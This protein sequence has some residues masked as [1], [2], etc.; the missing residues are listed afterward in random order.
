[1]KKSA[2]SVNGGNIGTVD[3]SYLRPLVKMAGGKSWIVKSYRDILPASKDVRTYFEPFVGGGAVA[4][5]YIGKIPCIIG[6]KNEKLVAMYQGV[7]SEVGTI[8]KLLR[9]LTYDKDVYMR[10]RSDFN[11]RWSVASQSERAAWFLYLNKTC[12][13]GLFRTNKRGEFN[14]P[15]GAY[16]TPCI[17]DEENL[18]AWNKAFNDSGVELCAADFE[19]CLSLAGEGDFALIDPPYVPANTTTSTFTEYQA[20]GFGPEDQHRL[21]AL[22]VDLDRR[23]VKFLLTNAGGARSLYTSAGEAWHVKDVGVK[24]AINS[25]ASKRGEVKEIMVANYPLVERSKT[26]AEVL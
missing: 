21:A 3:A 26:L 22:L 6:D 10:V 18:L 15:F 19:K 12:F 25:N 13:N 2:K 1:M 7:Q 17:C 23:G 20:G 24:R 9:G 8:V 5:V 14:V 16:T 11:H 4:G